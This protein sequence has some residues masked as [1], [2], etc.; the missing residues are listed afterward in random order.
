[1]TDITFTIES[2][3]DQLNAMDIIACERV[4]RIRAVT[5]V[6]GDQPVSVYFDGDNEKPWKPSLGMRRVLSTAY[7]LESDQWIGKH[8]ALYFDPDVTWAGK[9]VG[10]IRVRA[11]SDISKEG[12]K[13][14]QAIS[15]QKRVE[16]FISYLEPVISEY[17]VDKFDKAAPTMIKMMTEGTKTLQQ[18]IAQC[19]KTGT[20]TKA[21]LEYLEQAAPIE[22]E[23]DEDEEM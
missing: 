5:V 4:I 13:M 9:K 10:G 17:P 21:Q 23:T 8:A 6:K 11:L 16:L 15:K 7:G 2:K 12:L 22:T 14:S 3:S 18:I 20:L 1:M 19:Q